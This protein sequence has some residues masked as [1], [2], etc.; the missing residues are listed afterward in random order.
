MLLGAAY[1]IMI[2]N[3]REMDQMRHVH[4]DMENMARNMEMQ[5]L[6]YGYELVCMGL[7]DMTTM[8]EIMTMFVELG[9]DGIRQWVALPRADEY[10]REFLTFGEDRHITRI[11]RMKK[12]SL[13]KLCGMLEPF[14]ER[15]VTWYKIPLSV[16]LRVCV[17]LFWTGHGVS[18]PVL[19]QLFGIGRSSAG[20]I[21]WDIVQNIT[22]HLYRQYIVFPDRAEAQTLA[23]RTEHRTQM[24][25]PQCFLFYDGVH[26]PIIRP[27][28]DGDTYFNRTGFY[29]VTSL[30]AC[31][32]YRRFRY[33]LTGFPGS[34]HDATLWKE[35]DLEA[36]I[37]VISPSHRPPQ[38]VRCVTIA[39]GNEPDSVV[40]IPLFALGDSAFGNSH[41]RATTFEQAQI[42]NCP[43]T[44]K[45]NKLLSSARYVVE[46]AFG[47]LKSRFRIMSRPLHCAVNNPER[48]A[49]HIDACVFLHNFCIDE[50]D[51]WEMDAEEEQE[52]IENYNQRFA[53]PQ[54]DGMDAVNNNVEVGGYR[55]RDE[56]LRYIGSI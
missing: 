41:N 4:D 31:D 50:I 47:I 6:L 55:V 1:Q 10:S 36:K 15:Q 48:V 7:M 18:L 45:L 43:N 30:M 49:F 13:M 5:L 32:V 27:A 9:A 26:I 14:I 34:V 23:I 53:I 2:E 29:S 12:A 46:C 17:Y 24:K 3:N 11:Y 54:R 19:D 42:R 22:E 51:V 33:V 52:M 28:E 40:E 44:L 38:V 39:P 37:D 25:L 16:Q 20:F 21:I 35:C 56:L 8:A